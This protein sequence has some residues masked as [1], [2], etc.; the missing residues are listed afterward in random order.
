MNQ[1]DDYTKQIN[2]FNNKEQLK[3]LLNIEFI[4]NKQIQDE[5][6]IELKNSIIPK[7]NINLYENIYLLNLFHLNF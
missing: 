6:Y 3:L 7:W 1:I 2:N 5:L 4:E